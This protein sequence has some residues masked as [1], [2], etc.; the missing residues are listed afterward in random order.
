[1][2]EGGAEIP[3]LSF[4]D[5]TTW[6]RF[7]LINNCD[8]PI[9]M[10]NLNVK[11]TR[12]SNGYVYCC[13]GNNLNLYD[14]DIYVYNTAQGVSSAIVGVDNYMQNCSFH[15]Y[16]GAQYT[17]NTIDG[18]NAKIINCK[19]ETLGGSVSLLSS[20]GALYR[21]VILRLWELNGFKYNEQQKHC[22]RFSTVLEISGRE[23]QVRRLRVFF[24]SEFKLY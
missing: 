7:I 21:I 22:K 3:E 18:N 6:S 1:M 16:G 20:E 17:N 2:I 5:G 10:V 14:C 15:N 8:V 12:T 19:F 24:N 4:D 9:T 23:R 11:I 13:K